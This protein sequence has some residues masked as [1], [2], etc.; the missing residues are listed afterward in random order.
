[1]RT[2]A[3]SGTGSEVVEFRLEQ[4]LEA[5]K[6]RLGKVGF[7]TRNVTAERAEDEN[8]TPASTD[9]QAGEDVPE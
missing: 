1:M 8:E 4:H 2:S 6:D 9:V 7:V 5:L 3:R